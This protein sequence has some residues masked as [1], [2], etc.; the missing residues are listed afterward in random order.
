MSAGLHDQAVLPA[1]PSRWPGPF[2]PC[3]LCGAD[4]PEP[5][6]VTEGVPGVVL[7]C[8]ACGLARLEPMPAPE[9]V[10]AFYPDSYYG[11]PGTKF[12]PWV[13]AVVRFVGARHLRFLVRELPAGARILDLG[14]GRGV[15]LDALA[16]RGF[17]AHGFEISEAA[18]RGADPRA[19]V[20]IGSTLAEAAWPEA[21]FDEVIVWHVL[22]HV[23]DPFGALAEVRR[24][25]RPGGRLVVAVPNFASL[26]A[27]RFGAAWFH[28]DLPRHLWQF[29]LPALRR[30]LRQQGFVLA[31]EH[32]FSLRQNPFGWIQSA[33]NRKPRL[34]RNGLYTLLHERPAGAPLPFSAATRRRLVAAG[35][36]RLP[37]ALLLTAL[38][39]LLRSGA[40]VHVVARKPPA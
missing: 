24:V 4:S 12:T 18:A 31:S 38:E 16:R 7:E 10:A 33:L 27:R 1:D 36:V 11:D 14:C 34:P 2:A 26:Q 30:L 9:A 15:L 13:E 23:R 17:E 8:R 22:E 5:R 6:F 19:R 32:H 40:T 20:R 29:P 28:L 35:L 37:G 21:F 25:L 39:T 3:P